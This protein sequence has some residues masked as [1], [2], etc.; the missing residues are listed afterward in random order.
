MATPRSM[1]ITK[2]AAIALLALS[3][4]AYAQNEDEE[5]E[6]TEETVDEIVVVVDR[7][8]DPIM[9][10]DA[11]QEEILRQKIMDE[12]FRIQREQEETA[13]RQADPDL[14]PENTS[15]IRWGYNPQAESR[16][17]RETVMTELPLD[18][19]Q[20]ATIFRVEF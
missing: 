8:G 4:T 19:V 16:M 2:F 20:P 5:T 7:S 9:D 6:E 13:W 14:R 3:L 10:I 12:Y 15:R 1:G 17:R 18:Q 11:R